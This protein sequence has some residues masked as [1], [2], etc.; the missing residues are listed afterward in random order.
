MGSVLEDT[1]LGSS[2]DLPMNTSTQEAGDPHMEPNGKDKAGKG[3][4]PQSQFWPHSLSYFPK[5]IRWVHCFI[6]TEAFSGGMELTC[7]VWDFS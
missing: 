4:A 7:C 5:I 1:D 3:L 6:A 2:V